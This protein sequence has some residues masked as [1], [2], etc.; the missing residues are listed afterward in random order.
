MV[1]VWPLLV[2]GLA[3][4]ARDYDNGK[5]TSDHVAKN[6]HLNC[7]RG[8]PLHKQIDF[9]CRRGKQNKTKRLQIWMI[10]VI[11]QRK[12]LNQIIG[13][14]W[15]QIAARQMHFMLFQS[16]C[17]AAQLPF[18]LGS[19]S[20]KASTGTATKVHSGR[21]WV[22]KNSHSNRKF[23][24]STATHAVSLSHRCTVCTVLHCSLLTISRQSSRNR[25]IPVKWLH[26]FRCCTNAPTVLKRVNNINKKITQMLE[27]VLKERQ[28]K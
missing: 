11:K 6:L 16:L 17:R 2:G 3:S 13:F 10:G 5:S 7:V 12:N 9:S 15:Q 21:N 23:W 22:S 25:P 1:F 4:A 14:S 20:K 26:F 18:E 24:P 28:L 19:S 27:E 8:K